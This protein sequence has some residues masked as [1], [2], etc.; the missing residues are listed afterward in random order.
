MIR[1]SREHLKSKLE[2]PK[3]TCFLKTKSGARGVISVKNIDSKNKC[4]RK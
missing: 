4:V 2:G 1:N 3:D